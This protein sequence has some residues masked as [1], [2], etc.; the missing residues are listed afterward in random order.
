[1][2]KMKSGSKLI[3]AALMFALSSSLSGQI[4]VEKNYIFAKDSI[5]GFDDQAAFS[6]MMS[7]GFYG[8]EFK[9]MMYHA[10]REYVKAK[11]SL[12]TMQQAAPKTLFQSP[13]L[14]R[15]AAAAIGGECD[16]EDFEL[17]TA[18]IVGSAAGP[19]GVQ[20]W[21][22]T[23]AAISGKNLC[24]PQT[25]SQSHANALNYTVCIGS[26][27][28]TLL[29]FR[30][31]SYF[32]AGGVSPAG[33]AFLRINDGNRG[34]KM[35]RVIKSF[36][37]SPTSALFQY[38]YLPVVEDGCHGCCDQ[39]GFDI[40]ISVT[41][42]TTNTQTVLSCPNI[43]VAVAGAQGC[44]C[45][46]TLAGGPQFKPAVGGMAGQWKYDNWNASAIDLTQY[47]GQLITFSITVTDCN[48]G[49]H[50]AYFY[51]DSKCSGMT[52]VGNNNPFPAGS[53]SVTLPTCG[54]QGATICATPGLGPYSWA[55]SDVVP[56]FDQPSMNNQ[57]FTSTLST[58]YTLYMNPPGSCAPLVRVITTTI[59]PAPLLSGSVKQ[60]GCGDT[61]A[62]ASVTPSGSAGNPA[63]VKWNSVPMTYNA[64]DSTVVT[65]KTPI[66]PS[67]KNVTIT[68]SDP[69]GCLISTVMAINPSPP[70][71]TFTITNLTSQQNILT[72]TRD[73]I[74]MAISTN[75]TLGALNY[76]WASNS[77]T[78][79][80][81]T[82]KIH[83]GMNPT[84]RT[85]TVIATDPVTGCVSQHTFSMGVDNGIP[86]ST[87]TPLLQNLTCSISAVGSVTAYGSP[88]VNITHVFLSPVSTASLALQGYSVTYNP[89][90]IGTFTHIMINEVNGCRVS[91]TFSVSSNDLFATFDLSSAPA[92]FTLG[93]TTKSVITVN[94]NNVQLGPGGQT[95]FT[96][97]SPGTSTVLPGGLLST[98]NSYTN[99]SKPG[100]WTVV[101]R[102]AQ[103][104]CETW[105]PFSVL[106]QT[107][108]P[109]IDSVSVPRSILTCTVPTVEL[110]GMTYTKGVKYTWTFK[111]PSS[112]AGD[113]ITVNAD[114]AAKTSTLLDNYVLTI[115]DLNSTCRS[116]TTIPIYQ[117]LFAPLAKIGSTGSLTCIKTTVELTNQSSTGIKPPFP[118]NSLVVASMWD[119]PSPQVPAYFQS[120][121]VGFMPGIYTLTALDLNNG[122]TSVTT[123]IIGENRIVPLIEVPAKQPTIDCG[124]TSTTASV[125][126]RTSTASLSYLWSAPPGFTYA[127]GSQTNAAFEVK[128]RGEYGVTVTDNT[129]GCKSSAVVR[130]GIG[131]LAA[132][133]EVEKSK[134][135]APFTAVFNNRSRSSLDTVAI[136]TI[137]TFGNG[138]SA[139][140]TNTTIN[141]QTVYNQPGTYTVTMYAAKGECLETAYTVIEVESPSSI[142]IPNIFTPNGD[143]VNDVFVLQRSTNLTS[144][145][146]EIYDRWG[147]KV[148]ELKTEKGQ[149][150]W[151]GKTMYGKDA[152]DGT[153]FFIIKA[154]GSDGASYDQKGTITLTR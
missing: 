57:C 114:F 140:Y 90:G 8:E 55:G 34:G 145:T 41:N 66:G 68:V 56:P 36:V 126:I 124:A 110:Q 128:Q 11:Y 112:Q 85:Y 107:L 83:L 26:V 144:I 97:L 61:I 49:G 121:Y 29:P 76:F 2:K 80:G 129:N 3:I 21:L 89:S 138:T 42:T 78:G 101:V 5:Q 7:R 92:N 93:C 154:T 24:Q 19:T 79:T 116:S 35:I 30:V 22:F 84:P 99:V 51:F 130:V 106:S 122:C 47:M 25:T 146:A 48:A 149:L 39:P 10:K 136:R 54:A 4:E 33:N 127:P 153:Y 14:S 32:D 18:P 58:T 16:N 52:I 96:L 135:F 105:F 12:P 137:W 15:S 53:P 119:G 74:N 67:P 31:S 59:T 148:Y 91:K 44:P 94:I 20:G 28:D 17:A 95:T 134:G 13:L 37:P 63:F 23:G 50:G 6:S 73:T 40:K 117:N 115:E 104:G 111:G 100:T 141:P 62:V 38:A 118:T 151:D 109:S 75:Y 81:S 108:P 64:A 71:I 120:S 60:A 27:K 123:A 72:C 152:P 87:I 82:L 88:S 43:S 113:K 70:L 139:T 125:T 65:Y 98:V 150:A 69:L 131:A 147:H 86:T 1:M 143:G 45:Q 46:F 103:S 9:V 102:A 77:F 132:L 142:V 133:L